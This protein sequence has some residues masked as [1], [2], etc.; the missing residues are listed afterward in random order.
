MTKLY[1]L[2]E[3]DSLASKGLVKEY[4][5]LEFINPVLVDPCI[6][7]TINIECPDCKSKLSDVNLQNKREYQVARLLFHSYDDLAY[8]LCR[9]CSW[10]G[11]RRMGIV[12]KEDKNKRFTD[13]SPTILHL[14]K[15]SDE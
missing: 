3:W 5:H 14:I 10:R 9:T 11:I 1:T 6:L 13:K 8:V 2:E 7:H 12:R 4:V 15:V